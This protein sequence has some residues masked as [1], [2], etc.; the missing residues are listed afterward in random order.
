MF[1]SI[2]YLLKNS[3]GIPLMRFKLTCQRKFKNTTMYKF[4]YSVIT[5]IMSMFLSSCG[6]LNWYAIE[7][8]PADSVA[9]LRDGVFMSGDHIH[10]ATISEIDGEIVATRDEKFI[11]IIAGKHKIKVLCD[12]AN[13]EFDSEDFEGKEKV[14]EFN[15]KIQRMY[16]VRCK[17]FTHWWIEDID[18]GEVV[19]G[20]RYI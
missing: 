18:N 3:L 10:S 15:A 2:A 9:Y 19:A 7:Q 8:I 16:L 14:L 1:M 20:V 12:G 17:P 13:G 6:A 11:K 4:K 5:I